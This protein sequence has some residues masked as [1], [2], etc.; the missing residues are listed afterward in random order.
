MED[1]HIEEGTANPDVPTQQSGNKT[2]KTTTKGRK[3]ENHPIDQAKEK[4]EVE[5]KHIIKQGGNKYS[6]KVSKE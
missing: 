2:E 5:N 3:K 1:T 4:K 6:N